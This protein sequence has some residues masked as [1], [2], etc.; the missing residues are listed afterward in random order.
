M[1]LSPRG[2]HVNR[3]YGIFDQD[4]CDFF[5]FIYGSF[6]L[7]RDFRLK[8]PPPSFIHIDETGAGCNH[9]A[10]AVSSSLM[11]NSPWH[12]EGRRRMDKI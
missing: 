9:P 1:R 6:N 11:I 12:D 3:E 10:S 8:P 4:S 5:F 2:K 7:P